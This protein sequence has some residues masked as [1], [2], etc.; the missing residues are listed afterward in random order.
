MTLR[1]SVVLYECCSKLQKQVPQTYSS[2]RGPGPVL[3]A[4]FALAPLHQ[5]EWPTFS[6]WTLNKL[7]CSQDATQVIWPGLRVEM[8]WMMSGA[9]G[10]IGSLGSAHEAWHKPSGF[11]RCFSSARSPDLCNLHSDSPMW[12]HEQ[13]ATSPR[14]QLLLV[15]IFFF[16]G[17]REYTKPQQGIKWVCWYQGVMLVGKAWERIPKSI[18][19]EVQNAVLFPG[20]WASS[21][22]LCSF[23]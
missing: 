2:L 4:R 20:P 15:K 11:A 13:D 1:S 9:F 19:P 21:F 14:E 16:R 7:K 17:R 22:W 8:S 3:A 12:F 18:E 6:S 5:D 23:P 10:G